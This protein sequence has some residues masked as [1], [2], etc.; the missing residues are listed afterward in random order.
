MSIIMISRGSYTRG[1]AV[2]R[3]VARRLGQRCISREVLLEAS[4]R[5]DVP[6][7]RL[8]HAVDGAVSF[9][10][11]LT[12]GRRRYVAYI[13]SA[14][15][16]ELARDEVVYHG[17]A[18]HFFVEGVDHVLK[19]RI[20]ADLEQ[21]VE[22]VIERDGLPADRA[23]E[24]IERNDR[25]RSRWSRLLYGNDARDPVLYNMVLRVGRGLSVEDAASLVC[26]AARLPQF[27]TTPASQQRLDDLALAARVHCALVELTADVEVLASRGQVTLRTLPQLA[28]SG[29]S[30]RH[31]ERAA[32]GVSGVTGVRIDG[33]LGAGACDCA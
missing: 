4:S 26:D 30:A 13:R 29:S 22:I 3:E 17:F 10:D 6:E 8:V 15:L 27:G 18:G 2:A 24:L 28:G 7:A 19:V 33:C 1:E 20:E 9:L 21:R 25:E 32:A 14:L 23:R 16:E 31:L 12:D 5:F 11:R